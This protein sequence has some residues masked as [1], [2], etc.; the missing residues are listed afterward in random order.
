MAT[1]L[2]ALVCGGIGLVAGFFAG[3]VV[4]AGIAAATHMSTFEG[5][6]GYFAVFVCGPIGALIGLVG[7]VWLALRVRGVKGGIGVVATY[8]VTS[9]VAIIA[10]SAAVI[11]LMLTFD[12]TLNRNS[13]PR[14]VRSSA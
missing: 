4:G 14:Q 10:V 7:G 2:I 6:A 13:A 3:A 9:L 8:S 11:W 5:A 1:F 12:T